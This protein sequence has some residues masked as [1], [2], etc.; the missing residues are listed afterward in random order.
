MYP[1][2]IVTRNGLSAGD[3]AS[4]QNLYGARSPDMF[5][6]VASN[7]TLAT[8]DTLAFVNSASSAN[9]T[10]S[11][12]TGDLTTLTDTDH[13][14]YRVPTTQ[15]AFTVAI[16][17]DGISQL[18]AKVTVFDPSGAVVQQAVVPA[19]HKGAFTVTVSAATAGQTYRVKV[20]GATKDLFGIGTYRLSVGTAAAATAVLPNTTSYANQDAHSNDLLASATSLGT[21]LGSTDAR[22]DF[23][24]TSSIVNLAKTDYD[25]YKVRTLSNTP[26]VAVIMVSALDATDLNPSVEVYNKDG[27]RLTAE[28]L[29]N[30]GGTVTVQLT[31]VQPD[32]DYYV[33]VAA[34]N[35][36]AKNQGNYTL[37]IDFRDTQVSLTTF[38]A[39]T[40]SG[41]K[42]AF[43]SFQL[44]RTQT[45]RFEVAGAGSVAAAV[46]MTVYDASG[47]AVLT[48]VAQGGQVTGRDVMLVPGT[49]TVRFVAAN[50]DGTPLSAFQ[51]RGRYALS[52]DPIGPEL[53]DTTSTTTTTTTTTTTLYTYDASTQVV[54]SFLAPSDV[55]TAPAGTTSTTD[56]LLWLAPAPTETFLGLVTGDFYSIV[57]W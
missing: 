7:D 5:D 24:T 51:F 9:A 57:W 33:R 25:F 32:T 21:G 8:A 11:V 20:E 41:A 36:L 28:V 1:S 43:T 37:A 12:A 19:G 16:L 56:P 40:L 22:W 52:S 38:A 13:Y 44:K 54:T 30:T 49:Y 42:Q 45:A 23:A 18:R 4:V 26:K 53:V 55:Y 14:A 2:Y 39:G 29:S 27:V 48:L 3:V 6:L 17:T 34:A 35:P 46:R 15:S 10:P 47:Q 50:R 31:G